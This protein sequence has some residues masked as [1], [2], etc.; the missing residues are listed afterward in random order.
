MPSTSY[1]H[2]IQAGTTV[3]KLK[4]LKD[5][6]G[7]P[8]YNVAEI[9]PDHQQ[10]LEIGQKDWTG[11]HGQ[12]EYENPTMY[13]DGQSIDTTQENRVLLGPQINVE[14]T[15]S[16]QKQN[17]TAG[18]DSTASVY[19][20][21]WGAQTFTPA[22]NHTV[23]Y[24]K[25]YLKCRSG[26]GYVTVSIRNTVVGPS[27]PDLLTIT[28]NGEDYSPLSAAMSWIT[29][30][31]GNGLSLTSG[32][33][34][35]IVLRAPTASVS[36][37]VLWGIDVTAS[38]YAGGHAWTSGDSGSSWGLAGAQDD[39]LFEEWTT[40]A[41]TSSGIPLCFFW[42]STVNTLLMI[43]GT[44]ESGAGDVFLYSTG[45]N[46]ATTVLTT[47]V[48]LAE[49][50]GKVYAACGTSQPYQYSTDASTYTASTLTDH[51]A[52]K[53]M[54]APNAAGTLN[55]LWK[56][57]TPNQ[58]TSSVNP[59]NGGTEFDTPPAYIGDTSNNVTNVF[60]SGDE[61]MV[62]R[63]DNLYYYDNSGGVH[64]LKDDLKTGRSTNNFKYVCD[65]QGATYVSVGTG[66]AEIVGGHL[67]TYDIMGPLTK[68]GDIDKV[69]ICVG[70]TSDSDYLYVAILEEGNTVIYKGEC[71]SGTW[72]WS[73]L[74]YLGSNKCV[75]IYVA[76]HGPTDRRLWFGYGNYT[77]WV[78][79][80]DNPSTD[81]TS[82]FAP[83]GFIRMSY[84]YG[85]NQKYD[86]MFQNLVTETAACT[87]GI[88]VTPKYRT[89]ASTT[90]TNFTAAAITTNGVVNTL[91]G[92]AISCKR[93]QMEFDLATNDSTISPQL[94]TYGLQGNEK[95][96]TYRIHEAVYEAENKSSRRS[97]TVRGALRSARAST[98]LIRFADLRWGETVA[99]TAGTD[100]WNVIMEAGYPQEIPITTNKGQPPEIGLKVRFRETNW[101]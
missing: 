44:A 22:D 58:L 36:N 24:L 47:A 16:V 57:L 30:P 7:Q 101:Q 23:G 25:L 48:Q 86:K 75:V 11:G 37:A 78:Q 3:T 6:N 4:L 56:L 8:M 45:W 88:T 98:A 62:G 46:I 55:V 92:T 84:V 73:P 93:I 9:V 13:F 72:E 99:G 97:E 40:A 95:P 90:M 61:I 81:P 32:V 51:H 83:S 87:A 96:T 85:T 69:G 91:A 70:L 21:N 71:N 76:Q 5:S 27:G 35:G 82:R 31:L 50:N 53:F 19:G 94:L 42:A 41:T 43:C 15:G 34:Y 68:T 29:I 38:A 60:M 74:V 54:S 12:Y 79:L 89:D 67:G 17:Y 2:E 52:V 63:T 10:L 80:T 14:S 77:A 59:I 49:F 65:Y 39:F 100:Y 64:A 33:I 66:V 20:V 1:D 26:C 28:F 18:Y